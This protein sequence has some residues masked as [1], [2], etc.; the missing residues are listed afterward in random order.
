MRRQ[1]VRQEGKTLGRR[2]IL[3]SHPLA[4]LISVNGVIV[5]ARDMPP[6]IQAVARQKGLIPELPA[7]NPKRIEGHEPRKK[8]LTS[9]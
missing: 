6:E 8:G 1:R 5:D 9:T 2:E 4:W 7:P 3:D